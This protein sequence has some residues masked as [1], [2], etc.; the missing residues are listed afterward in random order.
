MLV[1]NLLNFAY[2]DFDT[3]VRYDQ[4]A[5]GVTTRTRMRCCTACTAR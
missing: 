4:V 5:D 1:A 3:G 2:T